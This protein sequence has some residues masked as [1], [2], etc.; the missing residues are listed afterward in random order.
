MTAN[1]K[2]Q[3]LLLERSLIL[4]RIKGSVSNDLTK[5]YDELFK[6]ISKRINESDLTIK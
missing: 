6:D 2:L 3:D 1:E 4:E 5:V